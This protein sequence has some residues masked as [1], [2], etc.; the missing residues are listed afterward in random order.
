VVEAQRMR[1]WARPVPGSKKAHP[2][3][4]TKNKTAPLLIV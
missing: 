2:I 4:T 1:V 3:K